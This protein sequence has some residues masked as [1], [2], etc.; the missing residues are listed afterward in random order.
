ML[1]SLCY[2]IYIQFFAFRLRLGFVNQKIENFFRSSIGFNTIRIPFKRFHCYT[3]MTSVINDFV[4]N[5]SVIND[6][7]INDS[8]SLDTLSL[9]RDR[10]DIHTFRFKLSDPFTDELALFSKIHQ[11]DD[12]KTFKAE[13]I[14]WTED[15]AGLVHNEALRLSQLGYTGDAIKKM[16]VSA[17]YYFRTK[18]LGS[19]VD[20]AQVCRKKYVR[21]ESA[22]LR[23]MDE[24]ILHNVIPNS[25]KPHD[26]YLEF[27]KLRAELLQSGD[28]DKIKK[29]YKNRYSKLSVSLVKTSP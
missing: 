1:D 29:T 12:R 6:S 18:P 21:I 23:T 16:F 14:Q 25:L 24:H 22:L 7:V 13:W 8:L 3:K 11:Y 19:T 5:D 20:N 9:D 15:N 27:C 2:S 10:L 17:R 26:G 28:A 4:I